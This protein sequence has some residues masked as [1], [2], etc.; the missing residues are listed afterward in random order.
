MT[1]WIVA[2]TLTVAAHWLI[3]AAL[4]ITTADQRRQL[5]AQQQLL[6]RSRGLHRHIEQRDTRDQREAAASVRRL[7]DAL[8]HQPGDA[9]QRA[10]VARDALDDAGVDL[11][12][13][14]DLHVAAA[15]TWL[16]LRPGQR[17][18]WVGQALVD[19]QWLHHEQD[20]ARDRQESA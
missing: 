17:A 8:H 20:Q 6:R 1:G 14:R 7:R 10:A 5:D 19:R 11:T 16:L 12:R 9:E 2:T 18:R 3:I 4:I 15:V 13:D